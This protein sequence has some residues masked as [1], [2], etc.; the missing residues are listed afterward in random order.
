M[1][2]RT[3]DFCPP[4]PSD[5]AASQAPE[6]RIGGMG[7]KSPG[8]GRRASITV[9]Y[10]FSTIYEDAA[11]EAEAV[12]V[13][14]QQHEDEASSLSEVSES[15]VIRRPAAKDRH[16]DAARAE[17]LDTENEADDDLSEMSD[18]VQQLPS[19][20]RRAVGRPLTAKIAGRRLSGRLGPVDGGW[21]SDP[22]AGP[23]AEEGRGRRTEEQQQQ[24]GGR[25]ARGRMEPVIS[26]TYDSATTNAPTYYARR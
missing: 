7:R 26:V 12:V 2:K 4:P 9:T 17:E 22:E 19:A 3:V 25:G 8:L 16:G 15:V 11:E 14:Q 20:P 5:P 10:T 21:Q 13:G 23:P 6:F 1:T 18:V 24:R